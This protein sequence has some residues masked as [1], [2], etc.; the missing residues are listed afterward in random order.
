VVEEVHE[1]VRRV[2]RGSA[3][4]AGH[5]RAEVL[6]EEVRQFGDGSVIALRTA[7]VAV[8]E[9]IVGERDP[10]A[11]RH[12]ENLVPAVGVARRQRHHQ[13]PDHRV[14]FLGI[15]VG[16]EV[17]VRLIDQEGVKIGSQFGSVR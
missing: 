14:V 5:R 15:L 2:S 17:L 6:A 11:R 12:L 7:G 3:V 4:V 13:G 10:V 16:E 9:Q 8:Q 1:P